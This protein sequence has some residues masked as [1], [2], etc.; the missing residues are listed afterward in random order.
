MFNFAEGRRQSDPNL[1]AS[2]IFLELV[3]EYGTFIGFDTVPPDA[4]RGQ[5]MPAERHI[6]V[7]YAFA[8]H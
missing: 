8:N 5:R 3:A 4:L 7:A 6:K 2:Q 1:P